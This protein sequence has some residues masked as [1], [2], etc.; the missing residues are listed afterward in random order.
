ML[1][2]PFLDGDARE[3]H[4]G[5]SWFGQEKAL[6]PAG[7]REICISLHRGACVG[8]TSLR[9]RMV[10]PGLKRRKKKYKMIA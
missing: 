7:G 1:R 6:R 3:T 2:V 8:V 9:E 10:S 4:G 5:L